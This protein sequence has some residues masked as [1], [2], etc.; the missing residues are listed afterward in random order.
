MEFETILIKRFCEKGVSLHLEY[1]EE[2]HQ[3]FILRLIDGRTT[4]KY[5]FDNGEDID[6]LIQNLKKGYKLVTGLKYE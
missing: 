3:E 1:T 2:L 4:L 5:E 6:K